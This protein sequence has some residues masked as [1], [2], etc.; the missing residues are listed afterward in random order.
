MRERWFGRAVARRLPGLLAGVRAVGAS[1]R[2]I[3]RAGLGLSPWE[4]FHQG[5]SVRTGLPMG[6]VSILLG[7]PI[8]LLW[9]PLRA[10]PGVGTVVNIVLVGLVTNA[11]LD[12]VPAVTWPPG[13]AALFAV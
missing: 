12:L 2:L 13:Q 5:L 6:T 4:T 10:R 8:L 1:I 9:I 3:A 7:I 11:V